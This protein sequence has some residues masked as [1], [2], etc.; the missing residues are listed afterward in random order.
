MSSYPCPNEF[1]R[2][3][4]R[5]GCELDCPEECECEG[6]DGYG[7]SICRPLDHP[8]KPKC[9]CPVLVLTNQGCQCGGS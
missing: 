3:A 2:L 4:G 6:G 8:P 1:C 9:V 7:C 5:G